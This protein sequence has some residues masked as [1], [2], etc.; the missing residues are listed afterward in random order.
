MGYDILILIFLILIIIFIRYY[1]EIS[2]RQIFQ[3][4]TNFYNSFNLL[5]TLI[6]I[7]V[8]VFITAIFILL[9]NFYPQNIMLEIIFNSFSFEF[10]LQFA[11][12]L[13]GVLIIII[14]AFLIA[15]F[16]YYKSKN[17]FT[18]LEKS[19]TKLQ[20]KFF[21]AAVSGNLEGMELLLKMGADVNWTEKQIHATALMY[22]AGFDHYEMV[23]LLLKKGAD[24]NKITRQNTTALMYAAENGNIEIVKLLLANGINYRLKDKNGLAAADYAKN[25]NEL[26][27]YELLNK[28][29]NEK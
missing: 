7:S 19:E 27:I 5:K 6:I 24:V 16:I 2:W 9:K 21:A 15:Y 1:Y 13:I 20:K 10:N 4:I 14:L 17:W 18:T 25:A 29:N 3:P 11:L 26:A 28:L 12:R 22:A 8:I 23:E